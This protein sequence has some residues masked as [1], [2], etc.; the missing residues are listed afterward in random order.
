MLAYIAI[1]VPSLAIIGVLA[2]D[3]SKLKAKL[4]VAASSLIAAES[5]LKSYV[6]MPDINKAL[7]ALRADDSNAKN[8]A[9]T[10]ISKMKTEINKLGGQ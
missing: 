4:A 6:S 10:M 5:K 7:N 1:I 2:W 9:Y 8:H 3:R